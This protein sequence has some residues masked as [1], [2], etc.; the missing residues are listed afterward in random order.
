MVRSNLTSFWAN[1]TKNLQSL[2]GFVRESLYRP[3]SRPQN[4]SRWRLAMPSCRSGRRLQPS[5]RR[6]GLQ[7]IG[8]RRLIIKTAEI[9][10]IVLVVLTILGFAIF[11]AIAGGQTNTIVAVIGLIVGG[12]VGLVIAAVTASFFFLIL[13]I[14]EIPAGRPSAYF[15]S[16]VPEPDFAVSESGTS[17]RRHQA[18]RRP[19][20][21]VRAP[22]LPVQRR[23][24]ACRPV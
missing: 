21:C 15:R 12:F 19:L 20:T 16:E 24:P 5:R 13:E 9:L 22:S 17:D 14:A 1:G 3:W 8:I 18:K 4:T 11:G 10:M 6:E 7:M 2:G 23:R